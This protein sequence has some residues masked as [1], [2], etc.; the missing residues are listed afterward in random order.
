MERLVREYLHTTS[1]NRIAYSDNSSICRWKNARIS[2]SEQRLRLAISVKGEKRRKSIQ[3]RLLKYNEAK[4]TAKEAI[5]Q[6][7]IALQRLQKVYGKLEQET[8]EEFRR[9]TKD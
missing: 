7:R 5:K 3:K 9:L 6:R 4:N 1:E 8:E 2:D